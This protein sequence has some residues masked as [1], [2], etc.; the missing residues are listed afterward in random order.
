MRKHLLLAIMLCLFVTISAQTDY[1]FY[2][3]K[4]IPLKI[5]DKLL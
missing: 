5:S 3:G 4:K 2:Q 1:Y